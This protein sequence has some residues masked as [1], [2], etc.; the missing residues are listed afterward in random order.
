M[1]TKSSDRTRG[2]HHIKDEITHEGRPDLI[3]H[4][5]EGFEA[6]DESQIRDVEEF[7]KDRASQTQLQERLH[8]IW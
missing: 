2:V 4:D 8:V 3:I 1:Q 5:S 6:G 7:F